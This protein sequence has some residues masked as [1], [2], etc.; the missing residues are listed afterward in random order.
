VALHT[1]RL[2]RF[3]SDRKSGAAELAQTALTIM[4]EARHRDATP[5][6]LDRLAQRLCR[7]H[8]TMASVWNAVHAPEPAAF[9]RALRHGVRETVRAARRHL[10]ARAEVLTLSY[11]STVLAALSRRDLRI[12]VAESLPGGEGRATAR[13]L[14]RKG[15]TARVVPDAMMAVAAHRVDCAV[16]GADAVTPDT[17]INKVGTRLLALACRDAGIPC[18]VLADSSK[19]VSPEWPLPDLTRHRLFEATPRHIFAAV[20]SGGPEAESGSAV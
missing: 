15:I 6:Q 20:V 5:A 7:A 14:S 4:D 10:P 8:P 11:S 17:V 16:V 12:V 13:R 9:A 3:L 19:T 1:R 2:Q 18:Y